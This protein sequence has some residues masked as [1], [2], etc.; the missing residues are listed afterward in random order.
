ME[1]LSHRRYRFKGRRFL[2]LFLLLPALLT[3]QRTIVTGLVIDRETKEPIGFATVF[4]PGTNDG[5]ATDSTGSFLLNSKK[6]G[7]TLIVKANGYIKIG[8]AVKRGETQRLNIE[9][10]PSAMKMNEVMIRPGKN[11]AHI[12]LDSV[13]A[14]REKNS[15]RSIDCYSWESYDKF[16]I[17]FGNY[18]DHFSKRKQF[19]N[20][21]Y[22]FDYADSTENGQPIMPIYMSETIREKYSCKEPPIEKNTVIASKATVEKYDQLTLIANKMVENIDIYRNYFP[23]LEKSF[24][25]PVNSSYAFFYRYYLTDSLDFEGHFC[26]RIEF[27]PKWKSDFAFSGHMLIDKES[28]AVVG[29]RMKA[30]DEININYLK[31]IEVSQQF[32]YVDGKWLL[33]KS[34]GS[35]V[36][37]F[38]KNSKNNE[39]TIR[40]SSS[41]KS[42]VLNK[43]GEISL[44][45]QA[46]ESKPRYDPEKMPDSYWE[47]ARHDSLRPKER[48]NYLVA[49]TIRFVPIAK[50]VKLA[51]TM[52]ATGY[53]EAGRISFGP[54]QTFYSS[55]PIEQNRF[56]FGMRTTRKLNPK[57]Q[58][59]GYLAY[60]TQDRRFKYRLNILYVPVKD[61]A[62]T[63]IGAS[64]KYDISQLGVSRNLI[65]FDNILTSVTHTSSL[66]QLTFNRESQLFAQRYWT[67][68]FSTQLTFTNLQ[69][70]PLGDFT[71][72]Y[73]AG[74]SPTVIQHIRE[75]TTTE[76]G[77]N[78]RLSFRENYFANEFVRLSLGSKFPVIN[79]DLVFGVKGIAGSGYNYRKIKLNMRGKTFVNPLGYL[80]YNFETGK[81][82]GTVPYL[83]VNIHPGNQTLIYDAEAF[84][85]MRYFEFAS[86]EYISLHLD[87]HFE[88][89]FLNKIPGV[90]KARLREVISG[91]GVI[92]DLHDRNKE[93]LVLPAGMKE[94]NH[95]YI[96]CSA[97]L[98]NIFKAF[99]IDYIWRVSYRSANPKEN[100]G[101][102]AQFYLSF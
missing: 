44:A 10:E 88:G 96:E 64:Y 37:R 32:V 1:T 36:V 98:E 33:E 84:N 46:S 35:A 31:D 49:D 93:L 80:V 97:G 4:F 74:T 95:P 94:P 8:I 23:I 18:T 81:V 77:L 57:V 24:I 6:G 56:K 53:I 17:Y 72:E 78:T 90:R 58:A 16:Q 38:M 66:A 92:G 55:N 45:Y 12:I 7:D 91:H 65:P 34:F 73:Q 19:R 83:F 21:K 50:K 9:L 82:S 52:L 3:A 5:T 20:C 70:R 102:K 15:D 2:L 99:R 22:I 26:Y 79:F 71:F 75:I 61:P 29:F 87:H 11:P 62:R 48:Y 30:N 100:W 85:L 86:D 27:R 67:K 41:F 28:W 76:I 89:F 25:S 54:Y 13:L 51:L 63:S 14:N 43:P 47:K 40:R 68:N 101:I 69:I 60:G 39:F 42:F 59:G